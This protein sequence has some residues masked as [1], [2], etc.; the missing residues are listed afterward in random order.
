MENLI[1]LSSLEDIE[2]LFLRIESGEEITI[3]RLRFDLFNSVNFKIYGDPKRYN[4]TLPAS[5]AQGLCEFQTEIYKVFTLIK[6]KTDNLQRLTVKDKEE[7]EIIFS[8]DEG[9]TDIL[10]AFTDLIKAFGDAFEKVTHGMSPTQKTLC[11]LFAVTVIGGAWVGTSYL[12]HQSEV[13]AKQEETKQQEAK[14]KTENER[15]TILRDGMLEAIRAK[16]GVDA[17]E[18]AEGIQEHTAKAYTGVLKGAADAD[19]I[20]ISGAN[21]VELSHKE[22][23]ELIKNP[24]EKAKTEEKNIEVVIDSIKRSSDKLTISCREPTGESSFPVSVDTSFIDDKDEIALLFDAMKENKTV[25][26]LGSYKVRSGIIEQGNASSI[27]QP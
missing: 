5:L 6:Y 3:E 4:G 7:A 24:I 22:I 18:R 26:I 16:A 14:L 10:A 12:E 15:M 19:K 1:E 21:T 23:H 11:F 8:I 9:C 27:S 17:V 25:K 20:I 13:A 2:S